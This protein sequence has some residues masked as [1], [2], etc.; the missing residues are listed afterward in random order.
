[1]SRAEISYLFWRGLVALGMEAD[2]AWEI[3]WGAP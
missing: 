1:M 2:E 3:A